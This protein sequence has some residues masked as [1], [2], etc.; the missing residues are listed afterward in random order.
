[1]SDVTHRY[2]PTAFREVFEHHFTYVAGV[3][4]NSH[5]FASRPAL[6]D[7]ASGRRW[8]Y[9]ELWADV[10]RLAAGL[11]DAGVGP[12]DVVVFQLYNCPEFA[13]LWLA[14]QRLGAVASP[15]NFRLS[16][17]ETAYVLDD[18]RPRVFVYDAAL[19]TIALRRPRPRG[20]TGRRCSRSSGESSLRRPAAR[21]ARPPPE[22]PAG[23][24]I[25]DETTRLYTSGTTGMPKGVSAQRSRRGALRARR[26]HA[27]PAGARGPDAEHDALVPPRRAVLR[28]AEPGLLRRRRGGAAARVRPG[29]VLDW[30]QE[31]ALTF[32]IG[33]PTNL[34]LLAPSRRSAPRPVQPARH[35]HDGRAAGSRRRAC[36]TRSCSPPRIFNGYGTTEAFWNTFLRPATCPTTRAPPGAR[37]PTTTSPSCASTTTARAAP[38]TTCAK[39]GT[40]VGEVIVR[41]PK[42]GY[43]YVNSPRSR[44][45][46]SATA[47]STSA[48][49]RPGTRT[50]IVTIVGRKDDMIISGGENVHP[51][52]VEEVLNEHPG[53]ADSV[54][55]GVP[56]ERWGEL[57]VAY[58]VR[59]DPG[60]DAAAC[61]AH[62][63]SHPMLAGY[64]RPRAYRFV[65]AL[66]VT[67]TGKKV[68][69]QVRE[70]A[71]R[72]GRGGSPATTMTGD[73]VVTGIGAITPL[74]SRCPDDVGG[75]ARGT[76]RHRA[77]HA[78]RRL[79]PAGADRRR[80]PRVRPPR[81]CSGRS[82][83]ALGALLA[84]RGR[85]GARGGRR[86]RPRRRGR[87]RRPVGVVD[88]Q[89]RRRRA[90]DAG[91]HRRRC[92][93]AAR[94]TSAPTTSPRRSRTWPACEVA[95]DLGAARAGHRQR[96]GLRERQLRAARGAAADPA[97]ARP[98]SSSP[99]APTPA[100]ARRCS[101]AW[102]T[103]GRCR[104]A[105]TSPTEA[106]AARSTP[107]ATASS[108]AR[109][110]SSSSLESAEHAPR[111][112]R[113]RSTARVAGGALTSDAFHISAP[114]PSG[115]QAAR[116]ASRLALER[117]G[118]APEDVDYICAHGTGTRANDLV[119]TVAIRAAF[120]AA[121]RRRRRSARRSRW[122]ATSSAPRARS[123]AMACL[124]AMR[125]G[126]AAADD[127][128][129]H[130][131]PRLRPGLRAAA[132]AAR[133]GADGAS[134]TRSAS[135]GRTASWC[136]G[137]PPNRRRSRRPA[138]AG[139]RR[140]RPR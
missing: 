77:D 106:P 62:C 86:R 15:I 13:L 131:R 23:A 5:R 119:E 17:G 120:G 4:R 39:D 70:Q 3:D 2:D 71:R 136:C 91:Q 140:S 41:S 38:T 58:V 133:D 34:A 112:R 60:V 115:T 127:Q 68:H 44:R 36:A 130:A 101:P 95:I 28:R 134:P 81:R 104:S 98:T 99:A 79:R 16:P 9:A 123:S 46:S 93:P 48:T 87:G 25:Y 40:E 139:S 29:L 108:S 117:A 61:E 83:P 76:V 21:R 113:A 97:P 66:P 55:V 22:P 72:R 135:A 85:R 56:D 43:A 6:H 82:G 121:A 27:L 11:A 92:A 88:Q 69:Y 116:G 132:G 111:A 14:A 37:A 20:A 12:G 7:P 125:D 80:G 107:T 129:G 124:L 63:V 137:R 18:S 26:D 74:G 64:K 126:I 30:V 78:L 57:V 8:T 65:D 35:R 31:H 90:R 59:S 67:A 105:T 45:R 53:V 118:T 33:A 24:T 47:G 50:S 10:G 96:A 32:L 49:S 52:Q 51:A 109:A 42:S 114:E 19:A 110:R 100:S 75:T 103:W 73:V 1:M 138:R 122:S 128:P 54:V 84:A 89:R 94:A 102:P